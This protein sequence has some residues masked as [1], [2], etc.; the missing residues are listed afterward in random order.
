MNI[1]SLL[2]ADHRAVS[3]LFSMFEQEQ[4]KGQKVDIANRVCRMLRIHDMVE[5]QI[6][7]PPLET[8]D[9]ELEDHALEE[10]QDIEDA[11]VRVENAT[12][13]PSDAMMVLKRR[14]LHHV[15][16]E[17]TKMF[18]VLKKNFPEKLEEWGTEA[19]RI[20]ATA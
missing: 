19:D 10:H 4:D 7:Y 12:G 3:S 15:E 17:E 6:I 20:K 2:L 5:K 16:E 11:I 18:P 8:V 13:D 9:P 14:V 1:I